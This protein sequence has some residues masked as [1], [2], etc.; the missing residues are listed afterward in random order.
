VAG[1]AVAAVQLAGVLDDDADAARELQVLHEEGDP[2][3]RAIVERRMPNAPIRLRA[4]YRAPAPGSPGRLAFVGPAPVFA[5]ATPST[6]ATG[7]TT[8][9]VDF[10]A[11][12][13]ARALLAE[14]RTFAPHAIVFFRPE[15][16]PP[17]VATELECAV[18]GVAAEPL[19]RPHISHAGLEWNLAELANADA[20]SFDRLLVCDPLGFGAAA[21]T[22]LPAWRSAP[23]PVDD[24]L[25]RPVRP[26]RRP[27]RAVFIGHSSAHAEQYL[28]PVKHGFDIGHY[29]SGLAGDL[30]EEVLAAADIGINVHADEHVAPFAHR[31]LVHL[32][33]GHL[34]LS[35][36]LDTTFAF[37]P[38]IDF[39]LTPYPAAIDRRMHQLTQRPDAYDRVRM[40]GHAKVQ[41]YRASRVWP[42]LLADLFDDLAAFGTQ[43]ARA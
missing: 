20:R 35:E 25:F 3:E 39:L 34:V 28:L 18:V 22:G 23:L 13:D 38:D 43:R 29:A 36:R 42:A 10:R 26:A 15:H 2:H 6:Q 8:R 40:R 1:E 21:G 14:L 17:A 31:V 11:D 5:V 27:P 41:Q 12:G 32:A 37:E 7:L 16:V 9:F 19:P 24:R 30:L 4:P 33:A